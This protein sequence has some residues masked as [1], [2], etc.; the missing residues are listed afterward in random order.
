M[1]VRSGL[2]KLGQLAL[3]GTGGTLAF[4]QKILSESEDNFI[5]ILRKVMWFKLFQA[6]PFQIGHEETFL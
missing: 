5:N 2:E 1:R 3:L 6:R 4:R